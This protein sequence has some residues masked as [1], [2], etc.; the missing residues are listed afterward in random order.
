LTYPVRGSG[1]GGGG[2]GFGLSISSP[3]RWSN[4]HRKICTERIEK[5]INRKQQ[6]TNHQSFSFVCRECRSTGVGSLHQTRSDVAIIPSIKKVQEN[7]EH[8]LVLVCCA[9]L[10]QQDSRSAALVD[11]FHDCTDASFAISLIPL[12]PRLRNHEL[13]Y[14]PLLP[15]YSLNRTIL[16][17]CTSRMQLFM[18]SYGILAANYFIADKLQEVRARNCAIGPRKSSW[19]GD[20]QGTLRPRSEAIAIPP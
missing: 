14:N 5:F 12:S 10:K 16:R 19:L 11:D 18:Q 15:N 20:G 7:T 8:T 4:S 6:K 1:G 3:G 2:G 17:R 13:F 9:V